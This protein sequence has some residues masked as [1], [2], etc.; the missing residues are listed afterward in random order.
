M[1]TKRVRTKRSLEDFSGKSDL[2]HIY[3]IPDTYIGSIVQ[4]PQTLLI[5]KK[6]KLI[7]EEIKLAEGIQRVFLE[8]LSNAGDNCDAS[9]RANVDPGDIRIDADNRR[10]RISNGGLHIPVKKISLKKEKGDTKVIEYVEGDED[11]FYLPEFIFGQF[12]TS[13]NYDQKVARMGCGRNGFGAKLT[14]IFSTEFI[15]IVEDPDTKRRFTGIWKDNMFKS[16]PGTRPEVKVE[17]DE[18]IVKG[19]VI[20]EWELDFERFGI[21]KYSKKD[22]DLFKRFAVDFSFTCKVKTYFNDEELDY[23]DIKTFASL[24]WD[25]ENIKNNF[26]RYVW[27][28]DMESEIS[29]SSPKVLEKKII[30]AKKPEHIPMLEAM[31]VDTPDNGKIVSYVNGLMTIDNGIHVDNIQEPIFKFIT[32][33]VNKGKK[34]G[35]NISAKNIKSHLSFIVNVRVADPIYNSQSKTKLTGPSMV[36]DIPEAVLKKTQTWDIYNRL[37]AEIEAADFKNA[38]K[39]D[40]KKKANIKLEKGEDAREAGKKESDKCTLFLVEGDSAASYPQKRICWMPDRKKYFGYMPLKGKFMNTSKATPKQYAENAPIQ[41]IK[42]VLGLK[43]GLDYSIPLNRETLRYGFVILTTDADHDGMHIL[44]SVLN[45]FR[46][47]FAGLLTQQMVGYLRTPVIK[48]FKGDK[49]KHRFFTISSFED[50]KLKNPEKM[51][52]LKVR[53][54]K[55]LGSAE[56][57]DI[58]DDLK[59]APTIVCLY[60]SKCVEHF[61]LAFHKDNA[62]D[63]KQWIERMRD[64]TQIDDIVS[65]DISKVKKNGEG[66]IQGQD[67]SQFIDRELIGYSIASLFRAIPSEYDGL[68]VSQ[69]KALYA[70]LDKFKYDP[71]FGKI[72]NV[73][74]FA[75]EAAAK[76]QYHHGE[77]S[78]MDTIIKMA[79][80]FTGTNIMG[81]FAKKGQFGSRAC[82]G[83][84]AADPRYANTH[85]NWWIPYVYQKE[86]VDLIEKRVEDDEVCEPFWLPAVIPMHIV[87]GTKGI[88]TAYSTSTPTHNPL[89]VIGYYR[90]KCQG[91]TPKPIIPWFNHFEGKTTIVDNNKDENVIPESE[92]LPGDLNTENPFSTE[93]KSVEEY[94]DEQMEKADK[95]NMAILEHV[96]NSKLRLVTH[97][98]FSFEG[99]HKNDG[100]IIRITEVPIATWLIRYVKWLELL[101]DTKIEVEEKK[102]RMSEIEIVEDDDED[103]PTTGKKKKKYMRPIYYFED[104]STTEKANYLIHWNSR[105]KTPNESNLKLTRSFGLSNIT[106]I[107]HYGIPKKYANIEEIM[108]LYFDHMIKHYN[109]V[110]THRLY[111]EEQRTIDISFKIK[112][113]KLVLADKIPTK[114]VK[115]EVAEAKMAEYKIPFKYYEKSK[116]IDMSE[117]YLLKY[118]QQKVESEARAEIARKTTAEIIWIE[119]LDILEKEILKRK[120]GKFFNMSK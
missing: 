109:D 24:F 58:E 4:Q 49:I 30:E 39:A 53:Y 35:Q 102:T 116:I 96:K 45:F 57:D 5:Y 72:I 91:K 34:K 92:I 101:Q 67:I 42:K 84:N 65:L 108:E 20:I 89:D 47:K 103:D 61:D 41:D 16:T 15:I 115:K 26:I 29:K 113:L 59:Y 104:H 27:P 97:G 110:R 56:D 95:D 62:E 46:E 37:Y 70:G 32:G 11:F 22:L 55:G 40:G 98:K 17:V 90:Q 23:R 64:V 31:V 52:G 76:V 79:Q 85:L 36:V 120:K 119:K 60:D 94:D 100:P 114:R 3:D 63:R 93:L 9:R 88:A 107:N 33:V 73:S 28:A 80:D 77:K 99:F 54:F 74:K 111:D 25:E 118:E 38:S 18:S 106:L 12:R 117:E 51:K 8:V 87:N 81:W 66:Q 43:E 1:A 14:N 19:K 48:L 6:G 86:S 21:K 68:K 83:E 105:W 2:N 71:T 10:I 75:N 50:W 13:N 44:A 112:F 82:G 7:E 69:R 78:L